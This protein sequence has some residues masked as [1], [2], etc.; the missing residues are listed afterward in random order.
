MS[1]STYLRP[2]GRPQ[3]MRN[4]CQEVTHLLTYLHHEHRMVVTATL[5][6]VLPTLLSCNAFFPIQIKEDFQMSRADFSIATLFQAV[7]A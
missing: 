1:W 3:I 4:L 7:R 6:N 5:L 2:L